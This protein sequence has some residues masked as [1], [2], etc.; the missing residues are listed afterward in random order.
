M[1]GDLKRLF[2]IKTLWILINITCAGI[3]AVQLVHV[4]TGYLKPTITKTWEK[5]MPLQDMDFPLVIK[6]CV[7]PGLNQ[8]ALK[9]I[10]YKD[11]WD[12]FLGRSSFNSSVYGWAGH[13]KNS[14]NIKSVKEISEHVSDFEIE[15]IFSYITVYTRDAGT[16]DIPLKQLK[17]NR[18][19]YPNNCHSL[20]LSTSRKLKGKEIQQLFL[21]VRDLG[22]HTIWIHFVGNTLVTGR[23]IREQS[24]S[25][26]GDPIKLKSN[27]I[28]RAYMVDINQRVFVEED[29]SSNCRDYP[30]QEYQS[31][32]ECDNQ[33]MRKTLPAELTPIWITDHVDSITTREIYEN[34][35]TISKHELN[36]NN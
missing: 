6:V 4:L 29:P 32:Q 27:R 1:I 18:D 11:T 31:Y 28:E 25:S 16:I 33:F 36:Q 20:S 21:G 24:R 30:N 17:L 15:K 10:G 2:T 35:T 23:M 26:T 22:N 34:E 3:L 9:E 13:T 14:G 7:N 5:E 12:Y 8:T 19:N